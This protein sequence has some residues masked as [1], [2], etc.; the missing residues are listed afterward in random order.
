VPDER[1][2]PLYRP[3]LDEAE[4]EAARRAIFSGWVAQGPEVAAFERELAAAVGAPH[5]VAVSSG[6]A[7]LH[8]ALLVAGVRPGDDVITVSHSFVATANSIRYCGARPVL[9]NVDPTTYNLDPERLEAAITS[10]ARAALCVHQI[11]MPC[12]L[13]AI[14]GIARARG[15]AIVEDSRPLPPCGLRRS[16][17]GH[18]ATG[19][20]TAS[21]CATTSTSPASWST[22]MPPASRRSPASCA[23]IVSALFRASVGRAARTR[24]AMVRA[25]A[26]IFARANGRG[27]TGSSC[28]SST[29]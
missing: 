16:R 19:R 22:C 24:P 4:A 21:A 15:L 8:L 11:G 12:D 10:R 27:I 20:A 3:V 17:R 18:G 28:R 29:T 23:P 2:I 9:V 25:T 26:R 13:P 7:A 5:A 6:T 1:R 14:V